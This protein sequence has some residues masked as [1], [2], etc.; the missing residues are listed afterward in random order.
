MNMPTDIATALRHLED[1]LCER[2]RGTGRAYTLVLVPHS[3]DEPVHISLNGK[4]TE[5]QWDVSAAR[6]VEVAEGER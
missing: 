2:E 3:N 4:P 5:P 6:V 1:L